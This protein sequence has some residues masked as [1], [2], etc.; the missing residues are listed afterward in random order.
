M[1]CDDTHGA[2]DKRKLVETA[3]SGTLPDGKP[4]GVYLTPAGGARFGPKSFTYQIRGR[5]TAGALGTVHGTFPF[6]MSGVTRRKAR[7]VGSSKCRA[8]RTSG[9]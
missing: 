9:K 3:L 5:L 8:G 6:T 1:M 7:A 2:N 4:A